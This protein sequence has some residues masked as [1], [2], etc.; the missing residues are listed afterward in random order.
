MKDRRKNKTKRKVLLALYLAVCLVIIVVAYFHLSRIARNFNTEHLELI[1][2]L[3]A[4]KMNDSMEYLQN[5]VQEDIKMIRSMENAQPEEILE[6]LEKNL[7]KTVFGDIGFIMN[8]GE[9]Y[10]S[11]SQISQDF[12]S[13]RYPRRY[14]GRL[15]SIQTRCTDRRRRYLPRRRSGSS[16]KGNLHAA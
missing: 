14:S 7:D 2:G 15:C 8:D 4:E 9:I 3:Y 13:R 16:S 11:S 5:Y 12:C 6:Q 1:T 10:G